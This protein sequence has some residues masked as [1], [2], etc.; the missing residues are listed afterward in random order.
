EPF[1]TLGLVTAV[2][3]HTFAGVSHPKANFLLV[4]LKTIMFGAFMWCNAPNVVI[5]NAQRL[6][7]RCIPRDI[8]TALRVLHLDPDIIRYACC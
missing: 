8:R 1:I 6:L 7:L 4:A 2:I 5:D 3:M